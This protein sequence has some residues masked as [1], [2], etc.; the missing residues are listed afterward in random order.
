MQFFI[1]QVKNFKAANLHQ[2]FQYV[3]LCFRLCL[4]VCLFLLLLC[5]VFLLLYF[6]F[7]SLCV[8]FLIWIYIKM[9]KSAALSILLYIID[10]ILQW[11][12]K[13]YV[14]IR[15]RWLTL[16]ISSKWESVQRVSQF[17]NVVSLPDHYKLLCLRRSPP[18]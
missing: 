7:L 15:I 3:S 13:S 2:M 10:I 1:L 17:N 11:I 18:V 6:L 9:L 16:Q 8:C 4:F 14:G 12:L 5:F